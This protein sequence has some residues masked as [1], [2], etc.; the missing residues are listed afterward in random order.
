MFTE[1]RQICAGGISCAV[2]DRMSTRESKHT[3]KDVT[4]MRLIEDRGK[5]LVYINSQETIISNFRNQLHC[6][7]FFYRDIRWYES[8]VESLLSIREEWW[9]C[10]TAKHSREPSVLHPPQLFERDAF[11]TSFA[12]CLSS[13]DWAERATGHV[14][15]PIQ[16]SYFPNLMPL[17][18]NTEPTVL[19]VEGVLTKSRIYLSMLAGR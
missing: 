13:T 10:M 14:C 3:Q 17:S 18:S 16:K 12:L 4:V 1:I 6:D 19:F 8:R 15:F 2:S 5:T 9:G 7:G 11:S